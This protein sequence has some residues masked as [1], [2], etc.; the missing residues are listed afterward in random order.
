VRIDI[1]IALILMLIPLFG[2]RGF[3]VYIYWIAITGIYIIYIAHLTKEWK[4][5]D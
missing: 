1:L 5:E 4:N 2:V 3:E